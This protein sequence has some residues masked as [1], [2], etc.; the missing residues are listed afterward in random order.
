MAFRNF[1][2]A[3]DDD[4]LAFLPKEPSLGFGIG[5]PSSLVNTEPLKDAEEPKV[6]LAE[7]TT[8]SG[9]ILKT[10]VFVVHPGSVAACIRERKC[11]TRGGSLMPL[12]KRK[13]ASRLSSSHAVCAKNSASKDDAPFL[14]ISD[15][16]EGLLDCFK[17]K[18]ASACHLKIFAITPPAWKCHLIKWIWNYLIFMI[19]VIVRIKSILEVTAAK[20]CV[21]A[22]KQKLVMFFNFDEKYAK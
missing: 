4:D 2:Y 12:V 20:V 11:K 3:K 7:V 21:T 10:G 5:S 14:S 13:L 19:A 9:E 8:Y 1:I 6:Q 22:A 15:D 18:D 17:L 16:D